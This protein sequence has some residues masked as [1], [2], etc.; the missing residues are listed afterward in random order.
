MPRV[1]A[2][3]TATVTA[4]PPVTGSGAWHATG[5]GIIPPAPP[6]PTPAPALPPVAAAPP[7]VPE[8]LP[9][10][11]PLAPA[12]TPP[13]PTTLTPPVPLPPLAPTA[14]PPVPLLLPPVPF[15][16]APPVAL[17][18]ELLLLQAPRSTSEIALARK[19]PEPMTEPMTEPKDEPEER[20][21]ERTMS[22]LHEDNHRTIPESATES[23]SALDPRLRQRRKGQSGKAAKRQSGLT[24]ESWT[25]RLVARNTESSSTSST[26]MPE[27]RAF[28]PTGLRAP[29]R[30]QPG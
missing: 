2:R 4:V 14:L 19:K 13:L 1:V 18:L 16:P 29:G 23:T 24:K 7:P 17:P 11:P 8:R 20:R 22:N 3:S 25:S 5:T 21:V 9:P 26:F 10:A 12:G 27:P 15:A 30:S 28:P 6:V